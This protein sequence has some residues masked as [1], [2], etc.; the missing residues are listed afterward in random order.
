MATALPYTTIFWCIVRSLSRRKPFLRTNLLVIMYIFAHIPLTV[1][2]LN[3]LEM[4][5][6]DASIVNIINIITLG[7][8]AAVTFI[9]LFWFIVW[10]CMS[11]K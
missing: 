7:V 2:M 10:L 8:V 6:S 9:G 11:V 4:L 5:T 1:F 3:N